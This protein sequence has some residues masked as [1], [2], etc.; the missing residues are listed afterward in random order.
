MSYW[1]TDWL[2]DW[3]GHLLSCP[4]QLKKNFRKKQARPWKNIFSQEGL[5]FFLGGADDLQNG[6]IVKKSD[7]VRE[8]DNFAQLDT[9]GSSMLSEKK[10]ERNESWVDDL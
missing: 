1:L 5:E 3:Q 9:M 2:T 8:S 4:G 7:P 6:K 10:I